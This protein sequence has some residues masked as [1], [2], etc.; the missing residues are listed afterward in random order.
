RFEAGTPPILEA[1]GLGAAIV[2]LER[3][4]RAAIE[5]HEGALRERAMAGLRALNWVRLY[6]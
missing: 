3:Q 1:I 5:A 2:W 6:G 4:D